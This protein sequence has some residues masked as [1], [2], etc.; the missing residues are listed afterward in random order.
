MVALSLIFI[1]TK[2]KEGVCI[3]KLLDKE[4]VYCALHVLIVLVR[5]IKKYVR[6]TL[7]F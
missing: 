5:L 4:G 1:V 7:S 2:K 3:N 6:V